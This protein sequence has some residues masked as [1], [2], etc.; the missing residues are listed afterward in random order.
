MPIEQLAIWIEQQAR[1]GTLPEALFHQAENHLL[2]QRILLPGPSVLERLII[3]VY[4]DVHVELFETVFSR[5]SP[6]L[7]QAIDQLLM[8]PD[9]EQR[10]DFYRLKEYPPAASIASIQAYLHRYHTVAATGIDAFDL[11]VFTP[12]WLDYLFQQAKRYSTKD[13]KRFAEPKRYTLMLCFLLETRKT[14]LDHLVT[15]HDQYVTD[16]ARQTKNAHEDKHRELRKRQKRA[17]DVMLDTTNVL[18]EWPEDQPF[19]KTEIWRQVDEGKVRSSRKDLQEF[20]RLEERGYGDLLLHRYPS[21]RKYFA[22]FIHLPFVAKQG[23]EPLLHAIH[24]VRKLD[25]GDYTRLPPTAPTHFV[26]PELRR[27]L[28]DPDGKL[29]RNAWEM[30][31]ALAMKDALRSGDLYLPQSKQHVSFWDLTLSDTRWQEM[32]TAAFDDL[33]QPQKHEAKAVLTHQFHEASDLAKQRFACDDFATIADGKLK[34][35]RYDKIAVP[36]SVT[37]LQK[38][39]NARL[40]L[41]RI[42]QLLMEV[43]Q[44]TGFSRHFTPMQG[45][46]S[47]PPHF[48]KTLMAALIS[49]ATNLGVVSMSASVQGISVDMLRHVL[50]HFVREDTL[51]AAN[52]ELVNRHH[53]LPLSAVH[54]TGTL[55]SSD[56]QRFGTRASSLLA[57]YYPRYYGYYE[58]AIGIYTHISDQSAVFSTQVISCSPREALYVLDGLLANN[59]AS[60]TG[61]ATSLP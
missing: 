28:K 25:A 51:T 29:N 36:P 12:E 2:D 14:L 55:S 57:S 34:L 19:S 9:G 31:L 49:Q 52:A 39:I 40:P 23:N 17:I 32:R 27:A 43:A 24:L 38:V 33:Q 22:D 18:L 41:I 11:H 30:G 44:L 50:H 53:A 13:L 60:I 16:I 56:A 26:P 42:E 37:I 15:M 47:R 20:K 4:A 54:G 35:K 46:R 7:R 8:V 59:T 5:L 21:L 45:H 3:H 58:K 10:S 1:L 61:S 6:A 48:Y